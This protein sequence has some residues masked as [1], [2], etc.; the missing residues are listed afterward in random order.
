MF[1]SGLRL[2]AVS[3][4]SGCSALLVT[5][6]FLCISLQWCEFMDT[7]YRWWLLELRNDVYVYRS[8]CVYWNYVCLG[9]V[10]GRHTHNKLI[11]STRF[12]YVPCCE[13]KTKSDQFLCD[14]SCVK[15]KMGPSKML[16]FNLKVSYLQS[17]FYDRRAFVQLRVLWT[18]Y[19][20]VLQLFRFVYNCGNWVKVSCYFSYNLSVR[21]T[22]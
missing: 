22:W 5:V 6:R 21:R 10:L 11:C 20:H 18:A 7:H 12:C 3:F 9:L 15:L 14:R 8:H 17:T 16:K 19:I 1:F 2:I 4:V 13:A